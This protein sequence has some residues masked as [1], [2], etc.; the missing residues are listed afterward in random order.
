[1]PPAE[2]FASLPVRE[3]IV[4]DPPEVLANPAAFERIGEETTF[5]VDITPAALF[6]RVF[7]RRKYRRI[8]D[9]SA[10]PVLAAA[11]KR[12]RASGYASSGRVTITSA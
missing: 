3:T 2:A 10:P 4:I 1:M 6:K 7:I 9:R 11:P 5:E 8:D 12:L